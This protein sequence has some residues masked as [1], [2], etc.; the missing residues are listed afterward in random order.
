MET[1][2]HSADRG[3]VHMHVYFSWQSAGSK[4]VD[5]TTTDAWVFRSCRPRVDVNCE[6]RGPYFW[7][8]ACQHGNFYCSV[9]KEGAINTDTNYPPWQGQWVPEAPWV[10]GLWKQHKLGHDAFLRLS[11]KWRDGHDHRKAA[12]AAVRESESAFEFERERA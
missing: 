8:K 12:L 5:H 6:T 10:V 7:L 4:G 9:F 11:A 1:S 3:R 2:S